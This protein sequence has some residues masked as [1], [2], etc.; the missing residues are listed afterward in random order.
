MTKAPAV[1]TELLAEGWR[2]EA[3]LDHRG[4]QDR[5]TQS[6]VDHPV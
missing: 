5:R 3:E 1:D 2:G 6:D 4:V